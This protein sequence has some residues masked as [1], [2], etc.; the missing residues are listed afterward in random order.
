MD[1]KEQLLDELINVH[2]QDPEELEGLEVDELES[3]LDDITDTSDMHPNETL[4]E[5]LEHEDY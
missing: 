5:F 3:L 4:E 2:H 1:K